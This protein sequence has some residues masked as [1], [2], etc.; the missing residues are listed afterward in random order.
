MFIEFSN[1]NKPI[2]LNSFLVSVTESH[3]LL[4]MTS[5]MA[6]IG[7]LRIYMDR[8]GKED[9]IPFCK[10]NRLYIV[11][12]SLKRYRILTVLFHAVFFFIQ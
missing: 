3:F 5:V 6:P 9:S 8:Y 2:E 7:K 4:M 12:V 1:Q 11:H 10:Q